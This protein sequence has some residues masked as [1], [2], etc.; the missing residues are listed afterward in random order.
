MNGGCHGSNSG[1]KCDEVYIIGS[2]TTGTDAT[3][4]KSILSGGYH[5]IR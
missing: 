5:K 3:V 4:A 1:V 2:G